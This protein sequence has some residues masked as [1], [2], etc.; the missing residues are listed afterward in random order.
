MYTVILNLGLKGLCFTVNKRNN[1]PGNIFYTYTDFS[2]SFRNPFKY[3]IVKT[4]YQHFTGKKH[5]I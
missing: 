5:S 3:Q 2:K 1:D 4:V